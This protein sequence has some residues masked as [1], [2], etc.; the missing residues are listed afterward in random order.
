MQLFLTCDLEQRQKKKKTK[1]AYSC[2]LTKHIMM[3]FLRWHLKN[4]IITLSILI[5]V[6][7]YSSVTEARCITL[8]HWSF[9]HTLIF[10]R[11]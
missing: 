3:P 10:L 7:V 11:K 5:F 1:T 8:T 6:P 4:V 2:Q 9:L